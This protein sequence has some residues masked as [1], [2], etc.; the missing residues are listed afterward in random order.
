MLTGFSLV[1]Y[2][3]LHLLIPN[4]RALHCVLSAIIFN[5]IVLHTPMAVFQ[6]GA[7]SSS[8]SRF[9]TLAKTMELIQVLGF[10]IQETAICGVYIYAARRVAKTTFDNKV[11]RTAWTL[12]L[13]Q[14]LVL[15]LNVLLILLDFA[16]YG[17]LKILIQAFVYAVK[18]EMEVAVLEGLE[19]VEGLV[20]TRDKGGD[21]RC[22]RE[23]E[24]SEERAVTWRE[25]SEWVGVVEETVVGQSLGRGFDLS[26]VRQY[27]AGKTDTVEAEVGAW[28]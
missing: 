3:R 19:D 14:D 27:V 4:P 21:R 22:W 6:L 28:D 8:R 13:V 17:M 11:K 5:A 2:S 10:S 12:V 25:S 20:V 24:R 9:Q 26:E 16:G 15:L 23:T 18:L 7:V 1:L